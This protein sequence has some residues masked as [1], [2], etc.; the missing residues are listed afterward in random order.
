MLL[1]ARHVIPTENLSPS[2]AKLLLSFFGGRMALLHCRIINVTDKH[3]SSLL[4]INTTHSDEEVCS[5]C[6]YVGVMLILHK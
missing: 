3:P 1:L 5:S 4:T 2:L 6:I